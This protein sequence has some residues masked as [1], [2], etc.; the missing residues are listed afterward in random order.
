MHHDRQPNVQVWFKVYRLAIVQ[1]CG[2][3]TQMRKRRFN[4]GT[5]HLDPG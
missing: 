1:L 5:D 3:R 4:Q 2:P